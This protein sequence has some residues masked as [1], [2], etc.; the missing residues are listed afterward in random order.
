MPASRNND[1]LIEIGCEDLPARYVRPLA[2]ALAAGVAEGLGARGIAYQQPVRSF[3]TPR[4]IAVMV[5]GV[6]V[7]Q[8]DRAIERKG[9]KLS[10]A[11]KDGKPTP[12]GL[13]FAKS[14]GVDFGALAHEDG[15]L[16]FRGT[17]KGRP[18]A[19]LLPEIFEQTLKAADELVPKRMRWG[20]GEETFVRPVQWLCVLFGED[21][22]PIR[23]FGIESGRVT[24]GHRFHAPQAIELKSAGNYE[25]KLKAA[26]VWA[27]FDSRK[28]EI[29]KQIEAEAAKLGGAPHRNEA[30]LDEVTALVEWPAVISGR[31]EARFMALPPEVI[32]ATIEHNQRY[33]PVMNGNGL[34]LPHFITVSNI[35][36]R[37][38]TEV[39]AGNERVVRPRLSDALF[40]WEQD[41]KQ[42]LESHLARLE[43][44]SFQKGLGSVADKSRRIAEIASRIAQD[45]GESP[46]LARRAAVLC[47]ADLV[48]RMVYEFPEL[49][50]IMGGYYAKDWCEDETV[51][52]AIR[53]H[54]QPVLSGGPIPGSH[55]GQVLALADKLDTLAGIFSVGHKPTAGKDPYALRRAALGVLR[56][57]IEGELNFSLAA[58]LELAL[59]QQ[60]TN[61]AGALR[62][63]LLQFHW[64]RL[65]AHYLDAGVMAEIFESVLATGVSRPLDFHLRVQAAQEFWRMPEAGQLA[66]AHKR[67]R[68]I[69]RQARERSE[70]IADEVSM[71]LC[72]ADERELCTAIQ[73]VQVDHTEAL[74]GAHAGN[75]VK[76]VAGKVADWVTRPTREKYVRALRALAALQAPVDRF[77]DQ[78]MVMAEDRAV[79][80]NRLALVRDLDALFRA[81]VDISCLPG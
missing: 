42:A 72:E 75:D 18:S 48:T 6:A 31:M 80:A 51:S 27:D 41:R 50:G 7:A 5:A 68:N 26:R 24:C 15:Q 60:P 64:E 56:I 46:E 2:G 79:R 66:A 71:A 44:V 3:A 13:G 20:A 78:V 12:A 32:I 58:L 69:L 55:L 65:R 45:A 67:V 4:R 35:E 57:L 40:F 63:E 33:F 19:E 9:P 8:D 52:I 28:V 25:Q 77:F 74:H 17:Q 36:S 11:V 54:Y 22:V 1:L 49:Q 70:P 61:K 39:V 37:D 38:K 34:L 10:A 16:V 62:D 81:V 23:R 59:Q 53:E 43:Q 73:K 47:K 29:W 30:L 76:A 21:V 14:C